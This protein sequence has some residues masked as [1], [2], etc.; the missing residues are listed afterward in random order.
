MN[1]KLKN[2]VEPHLAEDHILIDALEDTRGSYLRIIID[3]ENSITLD[4]TTMLTKN[5]KGSAEFENMYPNGYRLEVST[6][7]LDNS[8]KFPFQYK[9]NINR[10]LKVAF[11]D[12][13]M[14]KEF[15]GSLL[16]ANDKI[17]EIATAKKSIKLTYEQITDAKVMVS[18]K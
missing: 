5:L 16:V 6:P 1:D 4:E 12:N 9:K 14:E 18:F 17:V 7:G 3:S 2:I 8:L 15:V 10:R 11:I 13:Q